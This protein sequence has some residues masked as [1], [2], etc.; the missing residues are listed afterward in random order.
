LEAWVQSVPVMVNATCGPT[1]EHCE[2]SGGGLWFG[3]YLEFEAVL[4]RLLGDAALRRVL[5]AR[6]RA[7]VEERY[8]WPVLIRRYARFLEGVIGRGRRS[9]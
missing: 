5:G 2:Q 8:E 4:E 3:S 1:R 6:G 7:Y 9:R